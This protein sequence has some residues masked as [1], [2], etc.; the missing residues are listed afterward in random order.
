MT[1]AMTYSLSIPNGMPYSLK[2]T[3][4]SHGWI[5]LDPFAWDDEAET[6]STR[7]LLPS[8]KTATIT[9]RQQDS[10]RLVVRA[11]P[12]GALAKGDKSFIAGSARRILAL[13]QDLSEAYGLAL[14]LDKSVARLLERGGG[15]LLKAPTLWEDAV[16]TL[17]TTNASWGFSQSMVRNLIAEFG[18]GGA[19]PPP[20]SL[21]G[22][23]ES[24]LRK[25]CRIGY[26]ARY[27][28]GITESWLSSPDPD[29]LASG[30]L[31]GLGP[32]G[33]A[34]LRALAGDYSQIP[35]DSEVRQYCRDRLG[36][37]SDE[38]IVRK[39]C[40]WGQFAFLG[41]KFA[42]QARRANWIG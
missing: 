27:L 5:N 32:Y 36:C 24:V 39:F 29:S 19:F 30:R 4:L 17:F 26:R 8:G 16:K 10:R 6:V 35:I 23:P 28:A 15:R 12:S 25:R 11:G 20:T 14:E 34:H 42:R 13:D 3:A 38:Q 9:V 21:A 18:T 33:S 40:H 41:Y 1:A 31:P 2:L 22:V 7:V 37:K